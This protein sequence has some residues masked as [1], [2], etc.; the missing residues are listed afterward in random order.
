[1]TTIA[2]LAG[3]LCLALKVEYEIAYIALLSGINFITLVEIEKVLRE[4]MVK[5]Q[6]TDDQEKASL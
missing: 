5:D 1:M 3:L 2:L 6:A 4:R